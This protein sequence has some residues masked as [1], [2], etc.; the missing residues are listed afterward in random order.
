MPCVVC[1][2]KKLDFDRHRVFRL[3]CANFAIDACARAANDCSSVKS[4]QPL[5]FT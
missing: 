2:R 4:E 1:T 5:G 3:C